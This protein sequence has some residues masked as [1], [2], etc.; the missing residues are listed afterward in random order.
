MVK[1]IEEKTI[2]MEKVIL[3]GRG[4]HEGGK[5]ELIFNLKGW[6]KERESTRYAFYT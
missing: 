4:F 6:V 3:L 1:R 2:K 5:K